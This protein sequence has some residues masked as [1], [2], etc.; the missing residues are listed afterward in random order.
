MGNKIHEHVH[1]LPLRIKRR[2][3]TVVNIACS[4]EEARQIIPHFCEFVLNSYATALFIFAKPRKPF[5]HYPK[6][7]A[8]NSPPQ[9]RHPEP[10]TLNTG[11]HFTDDASQI[12]I[13]GKV[14]QTTPYKASTPPEPMPRRVSQVT[15]A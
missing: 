3:K 6:F 5:T 15:F 7:T 9:I 14:P 4:P 2:P 10:S 12:A 11:L 13:F 8:S 1:K